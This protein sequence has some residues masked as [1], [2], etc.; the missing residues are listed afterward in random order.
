MNRRSRETDVRCCRTDRRIL[1]RL[2]KG[3]PFT[4]RPWGTLAGELEIGEDFLL[5]RIAFLKRQGVIRRISACFWPRKIGFVSTLIAAKTAEDATEA[6]VE[7]INSYPEVTHN[8]ARA[9][10]YNIWF[11]LVAQ[12]KKRIAQIKK[13]L[14]RSGKFERIVDLPAVKLFKIDVKFRV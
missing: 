5:R 2:Q 12:D 4:Q 11:T 7:K 13:E 8:Y 6:A 10:E 1:D 3:I 9:S 14:E